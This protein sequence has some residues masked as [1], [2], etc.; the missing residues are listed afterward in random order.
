MDS[1]QVIVFKTE[2]R[3]SL[4][5]APLFINSAWSIPG[6]TIVYSIFCVFVK[7]EDFL[8]VAVS[9]EDEQFRH[10]KCL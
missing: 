2:N 9:Q 4:S 3:P 6:V 8:S 1:G 7:L 10:A 5:N